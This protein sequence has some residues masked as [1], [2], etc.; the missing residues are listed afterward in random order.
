VLLRGRAGLAVLALAI[1][2][3]PLLSRNAY[4][5]D[6]AILVALNAIVCVGLNLL[7]GY[8]G[9]SASATPASSRSAPMARRCSP[10]ATTGRPRSR[11]RRRPLPSRSSPSS[12]AG[13]SCA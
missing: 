6:V 8:A 7:I 1:L 5:M 3:V 12:S 4:V 2:A 9:R 11:W 13:Q 10:R